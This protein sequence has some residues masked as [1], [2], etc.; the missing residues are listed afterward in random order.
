VTEFADSDR[1]DDIPHTFTH[2]ALYLD[3]EGAAT[4]AQAARFQH[5]RWITISGNYEHAGIVDYE[6]GNPVYEQHGLRKYVTGRT[7]MGKRARIY[8]DRADIGRA[9]DE[10]AGLS[11]PRLWWIAT[12]DEK[13]WTPELLAANCRQQFG[14]S[15]SARLIWANQYG[16]AGPGAHY[17]TSRLFRE[18]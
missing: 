17:D 4:K 15:I 1:P 10:L 11:D 6:R 7:R 9:Q 18:W 2:A 14:V 16:K 12:L 3:G 8:T 5:V 13:H